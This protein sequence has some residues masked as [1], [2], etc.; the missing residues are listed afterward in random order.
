MVGDEY[1]LKICIFCYPDKLLTHSLRSYTVENPD[2]STRSVL[3]LF[4]FTK[5]I[6]VDNDNIKLILPD[7]ST[8]PFFEHHYPSYIRG[9][10]AAV[11]A[12]SKSN[13]SFVESAT[14]HYHEFRKHIPEPT[15]PV[16]FIGLYDESEV[17]TQ[18]EGQ[19]LAQDLGADYFEMDSTDLQTLDMILKVLIKKVLS[20]TEKL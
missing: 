3:G 10:S 1:L 7:I 11:F 20:K 18:A 8:H 16:A 5:Q 14:D 13:P 2:P 12:F 15:V 17:V 4:T 6:T 19:S 9:V